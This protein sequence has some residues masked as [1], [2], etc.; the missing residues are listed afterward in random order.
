MRYRIADGLAVS[1]FED[2][3]RTGA[4]TGAACVGVDPEAFFPEPTRSQPA[5]W[6]LARA[7]CNDCPV[8]DACLEAALARE[9]NASGPYR[10]G[11]WGGKTPD[12]RA[13]IARK[14]RK[15]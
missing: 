12:E 13:E 4:L 6:R 8:R 11:M 3:N 10:Y 15:G 5:D 1:L 14:R 2:V 7:V 9:R